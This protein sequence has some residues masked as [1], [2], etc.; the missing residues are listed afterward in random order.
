[1]SVEI[2]PYAKGSNFVMCCDFCARKESDVFRLIASP[3]SRHICDECVDVC[4]EIVAEHRKASA[5]G[6]DRSENGGAL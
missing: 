4:A 6:E 5:T 2:A 1:M 3:S